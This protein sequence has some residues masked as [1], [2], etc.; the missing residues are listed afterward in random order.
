VGL[1]VEGGEED[2]EEEGQFLVPHDRDRPV[3]GV[4]VLPL[5]QDGYGAGLL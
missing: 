2:R 4:Q 5:P 1:A 3:A